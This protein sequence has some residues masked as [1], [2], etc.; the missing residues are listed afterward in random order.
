MKPADGGLP[1]AGFTHPTM[2]RIRRPKQNNKDIIKFKLLKYRDPGSAIPN[3]SLHGSSD[4]VGLRDGERDMEAGVA[5]RLR[6]GP[7]PAA[8]CLTI[9][10]QIARP[11]PSSSSPSQRSCRRESPLK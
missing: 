5:L 7:D 4:A 6:L 1:S 3:G 8:V 10:L 2:T 9:F 11:M